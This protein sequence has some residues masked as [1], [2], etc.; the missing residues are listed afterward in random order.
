[1]AIFVLPA[2]FPWT[3]FVTV[4]ICIYSTY[5]RFTVAGYWI[6]QR[7]FSKRFMSQFANEHK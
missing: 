7:Y 4:L 5:V 1:M 2:L 3:I 6:R